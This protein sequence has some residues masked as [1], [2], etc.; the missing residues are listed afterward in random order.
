MRDVVVADVAVVATDPLV[1]AGAERLVALAGEDDHAD[2][3]VVTRA[4]ERVGE[5]EQRLRPERVAH[6]G[7]G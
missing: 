1:A 4:V 2:L 7:R 3:V 6:L 5:L